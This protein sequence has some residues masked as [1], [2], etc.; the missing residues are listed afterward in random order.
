M[1]RVKLVLLGLM[2]Y[3]LST[4]YAQSVNY[5]YDEAGRLT[6]VDYSDG[7]S[8]SYAYDLAGNLLRRELTAELGFTSVSAASFAAGEPLAAEMIASG[9]GVGLASD[10]EIATEVPLP[11]DLLGTKVEVTDSQGATRAASL[12]FVS[13]NQINYLI[14]PGT[15]LGAAQVKVASGA[16]GTITGAMQIA[17]VA[18][19]LFTANSQGTGVAAAAFLRVAGDGTRTQALVFDPK[20]RGAVPID[21][22]SEG[23]QVFLL[24]FGTGFRGFTQAVTAAVAGQSVRVL[25]AVPQGEFVGLDQVNI[26]PIPRSLIGAVEVEIILTVDGIPTKAVMVRFL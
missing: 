4:S 2:T 15:T 9:F 24:L 14:P 23:D 25:G 17:R 8:I 5:T 22:G 3:L 12:F 10:V 1:M 26:G 6:R 19:S 18:P 20:T 11:T 16:G 7:K 21:L 13:P